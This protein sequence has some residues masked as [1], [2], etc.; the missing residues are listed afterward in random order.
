MAESPPVSGRYFYDETGSTTE[1]LFAA[2][3]NQLRHQPATKAEG[4]CAFRQAGWILVDATYQPVNTLGASR[5]NAVITRDYPLLRNDL[6]RLVPERVI[7]IK[8]NVCV[9]LEPRLLADGFCVLNAGRVIYF[10]SHGRQRDFERQF[11]EIVVA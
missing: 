7:L 2:I 11:A 8:K 9:L 6:K 5:R 3:M 1:P 4:L 10:P